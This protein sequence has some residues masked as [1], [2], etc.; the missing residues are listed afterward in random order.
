MP[1]WQSLV[2]SNFEHGIELLLISFVRSAIPVPV[3]FHQPLSLARGRIG[4]HCDT[5]RPAKAVSRSLAAGIDFLDQP[6]TQRFFGIDDLAG[7]TSAAWRGRCGRLRRIARRAAAFGHKAG[8]HGHFAETGTIEAMRISQSVAISSPTPTTAG[9]LMAPIVT[10]GKSSSLRMALCCRTLWPSSLKKY[11]AISLYGPVTP[12]AFKGAE[13]FAS[14]IRSPP[15]QKPRPARSRW[16]TT[17]TMELHDRYTRH[18]ASR[19]MSR[20]G[21]RSTFQAELVSRCA[22][23]QDSRGCGVTDHLSAL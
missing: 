9:P 1:F 8:G 19:R 14:D 21:R 11:S 13:H 12:R 17:L 15:A 5:S 7:R 18:R 20:G 23:S 16:P 10:C 4:I 3:H 22:A 2:P 6:D